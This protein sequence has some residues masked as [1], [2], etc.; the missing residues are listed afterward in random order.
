V[1]PEESLK[2][3]KANISRLP[4]NHL[5]NDIANAHGE[6]GEENTGMHTLMNK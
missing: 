1:E 4:D 5:D 3:V 2:Q 6:R